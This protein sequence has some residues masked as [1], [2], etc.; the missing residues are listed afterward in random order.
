MKLRCENQDASVWR[1][2][3]EGRDGEDV[4]L[5]GDGLADLHAVLQKAEESAHCRVLVIESR[6]G[7]FCRGMDLSYVLAHAGE[8]LSDRIRSYAETM[9]RLRTSRCATLCL[10]DGQ[11]QGGGVGLVAACDAVLATSRASFALPE[12]VLGLIPAMVL[13]LLLTRMPRQKARW[14]ALSN[15]V[16]RADEGFELGIVD[17]LFDRPIDLERGMRRV[18]KRLLRASPRAVERLKRFEQEIAHMRVAE[19][20]LAGA[21]RTAK[22]LLEL[23]TIAAIRGLLSGESPPWF[24][25]YKGGGRS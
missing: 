8:D 17:E 19:G 23:E 12:T 21:D 24:E 6:P 16:V 10:V 9:E 5:D 13:P 14:M 4:S 1:I 18:V 15:R 25:R 11:V 3:L 20:L 7:V 22:D 2:R